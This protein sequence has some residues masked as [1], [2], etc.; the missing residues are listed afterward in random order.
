MLQR[1]PLVIG[2]AIIIIIPVIAIAWWL[3]S[4]LFISKTVNE[5]LTFSANAVVPQGMTPIEVE[6]IMAGMSKIDS[7]VDDAMPAAIAMPATAAAPDAAS[8][9]SAADGPI[10]VKSGDLRDADRS[11]KGSGQATI[12]QSPDGS[13]ILRLENLNVTNG[14]ALHVILTPH[15][16]PMSRSDVNTPGYVDLGSL[17]GNMGNQNYEIP[18]D[19]DIASQGSIVIYCMPFHVIFSVAP[20]QDAG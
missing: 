8:P 4:P 14:P 3:L 17:K 15:P 5:E 20:L 18:S 9:E 13:N 6:Q 16:D 2:A 12:Y 1:K 11:H 19:V 7:T 10:R